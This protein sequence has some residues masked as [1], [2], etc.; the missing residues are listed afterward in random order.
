VLVAY[1]S[2]FGATQQV[3]EAIADGLRDAVETDCRDVRRLSPFE[4]RRFDLVV[5]GAPTHAR[6]LPTRAS[7]AEG[8]TWLDGRMRGAHLD[9]L[10]LTPGVR[11]WLEHTSLT[12]LKVAAFT[13]R[14]D[15]PRVLSGSALPGI[16]RRLRHAGAI[17]DGRGYEAMVDEHGRLREGEADRAREWGRILGRSLR[18]EARV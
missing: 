11:E 12:G 1:E 3:A 7:R 13:T 2:L 14:A 15:L 9:D 8:A 17:V 10:A 6:S 5:V 16:A 18:R 4:L